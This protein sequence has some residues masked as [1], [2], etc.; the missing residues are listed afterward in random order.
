MKNYR[1]IDDLFREGA[2]GFEMTP[3]DGLWT[4]IEARHFGRK[5]SNRKLIYF[6]SVAA[7]LLL[8]AGLSGWFALDLG[9]GEKTSRSQQIVEDVGTVQQSEEEKTTVAI[10]GT[11]ETLEHISVEEPAASNNETAV[12]VIV[13]DQEATAQNV[14]EEELPTEMNTSLS[15]AVEETLI[16]ENLPFRGIEEIAGMSPE[17]IDP[18]SVKGMEEYLK[19]RN[20]IHFYTGVGATGAM[21]YYPSTTDQFTWSADLALGL[22]VH[23]FYFE[24]GVGYQEMQERGIYQIDF[25]S[26]DSIGYFNE[27]VSFEIDPQ[28]PDQITYKTKKTT[29]YDS[30]DHYIHSTPLF[31]YSYLNIPLKV[32][33]RFLNKERFSVSAEAGMIFSKMLSKQIPEVSLNNPE[34]ELIAITRQTPERVDL[35]LQ[36]QLSLRL[37]YRFEKNM[38]VAVQ[39]VF[40]KYINSIYDTKA[41]YPDVKPYAMGLRFGL[42]FDF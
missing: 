16:L 32:G 12:E 30:V 33:Y 21:A 42:Y 18:R 3:S 37:N 19:K 34:Y 28:N 27:V 7:L 5:G 24:S 10:T 38:S 20:N 39:P 29:V 2:S 14:L 36:W 1:K 26:R 23:R 17:T 13:A 8:F 6:W 15:F 31:K 4:D 25:R 22:K 11:E 40:T 35:N 41:G 9:T